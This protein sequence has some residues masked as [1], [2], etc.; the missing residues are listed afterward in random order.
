MRNESLNLVAY[1]AMLAGNLV[2]GYESAYACKRF[3]LGL[4]ISIAIPMQGI[5]E[6]AAASAE[7]M[8]M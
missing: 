8:R 6:C 3:G 5:C 1:A 2:D 4:I 7:A